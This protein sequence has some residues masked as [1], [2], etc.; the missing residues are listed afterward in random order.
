MHMLCTCT[1]TCSIT[2]S[3]T[4]SRTVVP[5]GVGIPLP[6]T[7]RAP[8]ST[9]TALDGQSHLHTVHI[10][11]S[12]VSHDVPQ[13]LHRDRRAMRRVPNG[14]VRPDR[15]GGVN[16]AV[17]AGDGE[18]VED[19]RD[20]E[21]QTRSHEVPESR[22]GVREV[23]AYPESAWHIPAQRDVLYNSCSNGS[24]QEII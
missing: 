11:I 14:R 5:R 23:K 7:E 13:V 2:C 20:V 4:C 19:K 21:V 18:E 6:V 8:H 22:E 12:Q 3:I 24:G 1:C 15:D 10:P 17:L 16:L 9:L